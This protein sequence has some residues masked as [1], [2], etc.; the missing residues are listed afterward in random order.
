MANGKWLFQPNA[1]PDALYA[2]F[3]LPFAIFHP[4][5]PWKS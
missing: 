4:P 1:L 3:L 2:I 5:G